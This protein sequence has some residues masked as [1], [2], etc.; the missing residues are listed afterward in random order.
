[1][2]AHCPV[3]LPT[4]GLLDIRLAVLP[5]KKLTPARSLRPHARYSHGWWCLGYSKSFLWLC[6]TAKSGSLLE[7]L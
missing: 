4:R 7:E 6:S 2:E 5:H 1:V 3:S